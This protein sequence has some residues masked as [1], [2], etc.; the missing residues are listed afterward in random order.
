MTRK[1]YEML[2]EQYRST[3][4]I[5][6]IYPSEDEMIERISL[7]ITNHGAFEKFRAASKNIIAAGDIKRIAE[8]IFDGREFEFFPE[9]YDGIS[10][11]FQSD[12]M[13]EYCQNFDHHVLSVVR[14]TDP[15]FLISTGDGINELNDMQREK[16]F[17]FVNRVYEQFLESAKRGA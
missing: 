11:R 10:I 6:G 9:D 7:Q 14:L 16:Y 17:E 3:S 13:S 1:L 5:F 2:R 8:E 12:T 15:H 4:H